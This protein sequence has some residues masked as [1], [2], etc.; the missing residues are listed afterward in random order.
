MLLCERR[1]FLLIFERRHSY[2]KRVLQ[3]IVQPQSLN[4]HFWETRF[5]LN[6]PQSPLLSCFFSIF[7]QILCVEIVTDSLLLLQKYNWFDPRG[8]KAL[9]LLLHTCP[10]PLVLFPSLISL[11]LLVLTERSQISKSFQVIMQ[12][13]NIYEK[14]Q[15]SAPVVVLHLWTLYL[16][17]WFPAV[18]VS[19]CLGW[20]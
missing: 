1:A 13:Y 14:K 15:D 8:G 11:C 6:R 16:K 17:L 3:F 18:W 4:E 19:V 2:Q 7:C 20:I 10:L 9:L 5:G 12:Q